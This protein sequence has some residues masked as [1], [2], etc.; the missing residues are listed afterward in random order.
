[1][2]AIQERVFPFLFFP[3]KRR[4]RDATGVSF[5]FFFRI[6]HQKN[7]WG[8]PPFFF[9]FSLPGDFVNHGFSFPIDGFFFP[10]SCLKHSRGPE[11]CL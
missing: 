2:P 3:E 6:R 10:L 7:L 11:D 5:F 4:L 8:Y 1:V 9:F